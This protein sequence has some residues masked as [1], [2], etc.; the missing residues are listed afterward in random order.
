MLCDAT[1]LSTWLEFVQAMEHW[2]AWWDLQPEPSVEEA[3]VECDRHTIHLSRVVP[4][5]EW[6]KV[7]LVERYERDHDD[8]EQERKRLRLS[9]E[10]D[11][12]PGSA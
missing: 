12:M 8:A 3:L 7:R 9:V 11:V 2:E 4:I 1:A 5:P 10:V 6:V